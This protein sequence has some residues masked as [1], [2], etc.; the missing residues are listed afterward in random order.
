MEPELIALALGAVA[1]LTIGGVTYG[2]GSTVAD[3]VLNPTKPVT[4]YTPVLYIG[5]GLL[6]VYLLSK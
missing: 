2:V 4:D 5:A 3:D 6:A 1:I